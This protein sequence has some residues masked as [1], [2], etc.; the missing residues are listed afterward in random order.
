MSLG[1]VSYSCVNERY[2]RQALIYLR[3]ASQLPGYSLSPYL[4]KCVLSFSYSH[5]A[6]LSARHGLGTGCTELFTAISMITACS[7]TEPL[8]FS[9][10]IFW[11]EMVYI[12]KFGSTD[13]SGTLERVLRWGLVTGRPTECCCGFCIAKGILGDG[14]ETWTDLVLSSI[15]FV[16]L[17]C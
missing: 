7:S 16:E 9:R 13:G 6:Y 10:Y 15:R 5:L 3:R 8:R 14:R 17:D 11:T 2:F 4:Q 12:Q 1:N